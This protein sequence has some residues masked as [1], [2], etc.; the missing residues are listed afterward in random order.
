MLLSPFGCSGADGEYLLCLG[1]ELLL[2][3]RHEVSQGYPT[4]MS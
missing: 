1:W 2:C 4:L 3:V